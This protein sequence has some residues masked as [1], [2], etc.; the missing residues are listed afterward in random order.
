MMAFMDVKRAERTVSRGFSVG[1]CVVGVCLQGAA[2]KVILC[3]ILQIF[4]QPLRIF[5]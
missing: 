3:R 1:L 4:K 5:A 2:K